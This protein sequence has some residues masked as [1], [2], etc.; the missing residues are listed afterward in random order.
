VRALASFRLWL[1]PGVSRPKNLGKV[2]KIKYKNPEGR[3]RNH[4]I[5]LKIPSVGIY[6]YIRSIR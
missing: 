6:T 1:P 3:K 2:K 5:P 4:P